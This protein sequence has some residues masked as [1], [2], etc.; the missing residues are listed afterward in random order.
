MSKENALIMF[1]VDTRGSKGNRA[2]L[3]CLILAEAHIQRGGRVQFALQQDQRT[4]RNIIAARGLQEVA[5]RGAIGSDGDL[6][7]LLSVVATSKAASVVIEGRCF[8][9]QYLSTL[10][11]NVFTAV[12]EDDGERVLP[13]QLIINSS[14]SADERFYTCGA[15]AR[16]LL[17]PEYKLVSPEIANWSK[18]E[19]SPKSEI[20]RVF[21]TS[22]DDSIIART[23]D[24][25]PRSTK[26]TIVTVLGSRT[27]PILDEAAC[28]AC[29]RGYIIEQISRNAVT[30]SLL[31]CDAAIVTSESL[32]G[33]IGF[34]GI[35]TLCLAHN[36]DDARE[37]HRLAEE[38]ANI[39][40]APMS[41]TTSLDL[42]TAIETFLLDEPQRHRFGKRIGSLVDGQGAE[43]ILDSLVAV[44]ASKL[45]LLEAA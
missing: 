27:C 25:L 23:L 6:E 32:S 7:E 14:F 30:D 31:L 43:R 20:E 10:A 22:S 18:P 45:R 34:L 44:Q 16:L 39:H 41:Q 33:L 13:V 5:I 8:G 37:A 15:D 26:T 29:A 38:G 2:L 1:R 4:A 17:G 11:G 36:R 24:A 19:R 3:R 28:A 9:H 40:L 21:L 35:P 42:S 12:V